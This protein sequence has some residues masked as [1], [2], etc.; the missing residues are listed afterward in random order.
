[1]YMLRGIAKEVESALTRT[2]QNFL[3]GET[4]GENDVI[5]Y[6]AL[7]PFFV[8]RKNF[9]KRHIKVAAWYKAC[10]KLIQPILGALN[11]QFA[12]AKS[13]HKYKAKQEVS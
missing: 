8:E 6:T 7:T 9:F 12:P 5:G 4:P 3:S 13:K 1:M 2:K 11:K 10:G